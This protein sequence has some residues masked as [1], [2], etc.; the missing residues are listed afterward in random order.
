LRYIV[1]VPATLAERIRKLVESGEYADLQEFVRVAIENQ[2][3]LQELP[4]GPVT[5]REANGQPA[6]NQRL[7]SPLV[8]RPLNLLALPS[9]ELPTLLHPQKP[10]NTTI[11]GLYNRIFPAKVAIRVM[12]NLA[13]LRG[14]PSIDLKEV[15]SEASRAARQ[16]GNELSYLDARAR[17]LHGEKM[18]TG[19]PLGSRDRSTLRYEEMF[20]GSLGKGDTPQGLPAELGFATLLREK[21]KAV[22]GP[23]ELGARFAKLQNP[24]LDMEHDHQDS[25]FSDEE[26]DF[27]ISNI[28]DR[29]PVEWSRCVAVLRAIEHGKNTPN[30]IETA[31]VS[32]KRDSDAAP[33][34]RAG[35]LSRLTETGLIKRRR[36]GL[37]VSYSITGKGGEWT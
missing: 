24:I 8:D 34:E 33:T 27:L 3:H 13:A 15:Q 16:L 19:L 20:V 10:N 22:I 32:S 21:G 6:L 9:R 37:N 1:D 11:W 18:A 4:A 7:S 28:K 36:E 12:C 23:T 2:L 5:E 14:S 29:L 17:K 26:A 30:A 31:L 35:I 25:I